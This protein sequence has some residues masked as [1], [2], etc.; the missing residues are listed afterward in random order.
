MRD[1]GL[2]Q[3]HSPVAWLSTKHFQDDAPFKPLIHSPVEATLLCLYTRQGMDLNPAFQQKT[4][5]LQSLC[6]AISLVCRK[7][8]TQRS[9]LARTQSIASFQT[10]ALEAV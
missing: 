3:V 7:I 1:Q 4:R 2:R 6:Y 8:Y 10:R 9:A 5:V